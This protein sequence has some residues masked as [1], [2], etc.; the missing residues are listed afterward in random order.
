MVNGIIPFCVWP[1]TFHLRGQSWP[2]WLKLKALCFH[3]SSQSEMIFSSKS[4]VR[5]S[6]QILSL[7][8]LTFDFWCHKFKHMV[9]I[10]FPLTSFLSAWLLPYILNMRSWKS[11][12]KSFLGCLWNPKNKKMRLDAPWD[13]PKYRSK[14]VGLPPSSGLYSRKDLATAPALFGGLPGILLFIS[15]ITRSPLQPAQ[16]GGRCSQTFPRVK[17]GSGWEP[18]T[19]FKVLFLD[20]LRKL[21]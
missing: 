4:L 21:F 13:H 3:I 18:A 8:F 11:A 16:E 20:F 10:I 17:A 19:I 2:L 9:G 7:N 1:M 12:T 14:N 15:R 6:A 5:F